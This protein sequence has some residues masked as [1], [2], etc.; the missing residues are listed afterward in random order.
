MDASTSNELA[1]DSGLPAAPPYERSIVLKRIFDAPRALMW[2]MFTDPAHLAQWFGPKIFT[3]HSVKV[4]LR[5]GGLLQLTM[6]GPD[7]SEHPMKCVFREIVAGEKLAFVNDAYDTDG[8]KLLDGFTTIVFEDVG[9][10]T[11]LT[12]ETTAK[13][14]AEVTKFMLGGMAEGWAQSFDKLAAGLLKH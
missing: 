14:V 7:G 3:N 12:L 13:G 8:K 2:K 6:R 1:F 9:G 10:K 4:D 11:R 5:V